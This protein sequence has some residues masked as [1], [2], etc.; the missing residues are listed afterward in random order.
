MKTFFLFSTKL[1]GGM[2]DNVYHHRYG[3]HMDVYHH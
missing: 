2:N 1:Q 3:W